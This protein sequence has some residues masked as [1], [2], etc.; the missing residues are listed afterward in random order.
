MRAGRDRRSNAPL[1]RTALHLGTPHIQQTTPHS[2]PISIPQGNVSPPPKPSPTPH[3]P[4]HAVD[5]W[6]PHAAELRVAGGL[7][8]GGAGGAG[9]CSVASAAGGR[10]CDPV[11]PRHGGAD[12]AA[13]DGPAVGAPAAR[14][15]RT[16]H[17]NTFGVVSAAASAPE[18]PGADCTAGA[19]GSGQRGR[20]ESVGLVER[21]GG[22]R[23]ARGERRFAAGRA[24]R[25]RAGE[26][27]VGAGAGGAGAGPRCARRVQ[28][29]RERPRSSRGAARVAHSRARGTARGGGWGGRAGAGEGGGG[30]GGRGEEGG[31]GVGGGDEGGCC[32]WSEPSGRSEWI[33]APACAERHPA[34][35]ARRGDKGGGRREG[36]GEERGGGEGGGEEG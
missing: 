16:G 13:G 35:D 20:A 34:A 6:S 26:G 15:A 33:H 3:G 32:G 18:R 30:G 24:G 36:G 29:E 5:A 19:G 25:R 14:A 1:A 12:A 27:P 28:G 2:T 7:A 22:A 4:A 17:A 10:A 23:A 11:L 21:R 8:A 9:R 31:G